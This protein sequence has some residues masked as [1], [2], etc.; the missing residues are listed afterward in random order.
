MKVAKIIAK[1]KKLTPTRKRT[2]G[3]NIYHMRKG[4]LVRM[5]QKEEG[6]TPCYKG[7]YAHSCGQVDC[8]WFKDCK[9]NRP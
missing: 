8:C 2:R 3:I 7:D 6:N 4:D 5:I 9:S 1:Y